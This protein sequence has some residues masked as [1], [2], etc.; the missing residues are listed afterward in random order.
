MALTGL[1]IVGFTITHLLGNLT[2]LSP[3]P[4]S[5]NAY[6]YGLT[7]L[8]PLL[9]IAQWGLFAFFV[10]HIVSAV[11]VTKRNKGA[12]SQGYAKTVSKGG[13]SRSN[14]SSRNMIVSG[15][16]LGAFWIWHQIHFKWGPSEADGYTTTLDGVPVRDL[17]RLVYEEFQKPWVVGI[18]VFVMLFLGMHLRHG[19]WSAFQSLGAMN[20]KLSPL[21]TALGYLLAILLS[22]GFLFLPLWIYFD[23]GSMLRGATS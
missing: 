8:G 12:R 1:A 21:V 5:F 22:V 7:K 4:E 3:N 9:A 14:V 20:P 11:L 18:Y 23:L 15:L 13:P 19:F 6:A 2:L 17:Y 16:I 10:V